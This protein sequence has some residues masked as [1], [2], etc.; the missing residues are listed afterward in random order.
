[1]WFRKNKI[2]HDKP[3]KHYRGRF[4]KSNYSVWDNISII[5]KFAMIT[6]PIMLCFIFYM[7]CDVISPE[8]KWWFRLP[9]SVGGVIGVFTLIWGFVTWMSGED[10][11]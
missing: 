8:L 7:M 11:Y 4:D 9:I 10:W 2:K 6:L 3:K 1:M 5:E